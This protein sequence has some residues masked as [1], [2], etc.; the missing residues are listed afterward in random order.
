MDEAEND[1]LAFMTFPRAHWAQIYSTNPLERLNAEI[2][3]RTNVVG[4]FPNDAAITRLIHLIY[5]SSARG[6]I[7]ADELARVLESSV[8]NNMK[9]QVTG[10]L[11]YLTDSFMQ[12][13]EGEEA[14]V[15]E[16]YARVLLDGR[17]TGAILIERV[18]I[19]GRS[20]GRW[21]MCFKSLRSAEVA[22]FPAFVPSFSG[23]VDF[24]SIGARPGLAYDLLELFARN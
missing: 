7:G 12:V 1:V 22:D 23:S 10:M 21:S 17:H 6:E 15:D 20:F 11:L 2:K 24:A 5:V 4:I 18:P 14:G 16:T 19:D 9:Q 13:L 3:R 8:R